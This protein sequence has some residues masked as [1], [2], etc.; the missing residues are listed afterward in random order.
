[1][2]VADCEPGGLPQCGNLFPC[3]FHRR[4]CSAMVQY[5][6]QIWWVAGGA[7][8]KPAILGFPVSWKHFSTLFP[9]SSTIRSQLGF[10]RLG[11]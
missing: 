8:K 2:A 1:M 6:K 9:C 11:R 5:L 4:Q 7:E 10:Q 3:P